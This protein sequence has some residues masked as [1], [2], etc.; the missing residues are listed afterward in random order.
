MIFIINGAVRYNSYDGDLYLTDGSIDMITLSMVINE[1]M[2]LM[3]KNNGVPL[4]RE[5]I[6]SDLWGK[7][8]LNSSNNNLSNY[9]SILRKTLAHCGLHEVITTIPKYGFVFNADVEVLSEKGEGKN[10]IFIDKIENA[11]IF[12]L[13]V[14]IKFFLKDLISFLTGRGFI[15]A[16][17]VLVIYLFVSP[18]YIYGQ[19]K[20]L[21]GYDVSFKINKCSVQLLNDS[22][23]NLDMKKVI[24]SLKMMMARNNINCGNKSTIYYL[25]NQDD[26][27]LNHS[28]NQP[29]FAYCTGDRKSPCV[30]YRVTK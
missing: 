25:Y 18:G 19:F 12:P 14:R 1:L 21:V 22:S 8:G 6:L 30:N 9:V 26:P 29:F 23:T 20:N 10:H 13:L 16:A 2:L 5:F 3:V 27:A 7:K 17:A 24:L 28:G 11:S 15:L 4:S